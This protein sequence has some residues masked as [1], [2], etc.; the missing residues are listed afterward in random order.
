M[1]YDTKCPH[2]NQECE[3]EDLQIYICPYCGQDFEAFD[4]EVLDED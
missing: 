4:D 2:C 3:V 1:T